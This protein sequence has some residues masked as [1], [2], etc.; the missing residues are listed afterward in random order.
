MDLAALEP[1]AAA[2]ASQDLRH[3]YRLK[4]I[5]FSSLKTSQP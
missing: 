4:G 5:S 1:N 2:L 3:R